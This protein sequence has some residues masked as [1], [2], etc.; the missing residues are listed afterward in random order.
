MLNKEIIHL[1]YRK[2]RKSENPQR[3]IHW[4]EEIYPHLPQLI[5]D[6]IMK[7]HRLAN[8]EIEPKRT[9]LLELKRMDEYADA[10]ILYIYIFFFRKLSPT[11]ITNKKNPG[12]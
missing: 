11:F 3:I 4:R 7:N 1:F 8:A 10:F 5:L 6:K 2:G 12:Y 9:V